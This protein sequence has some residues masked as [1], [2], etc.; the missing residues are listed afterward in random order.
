[1]R[2][3]LM[4]LI[5]PSFRR[6]PELSSRVLYLLQQTSF[7]RC[8][9]LQIGAVLK[10]EKKRNEE[11]CKMRLN[12]DMTNIRKVKFI[13]YIFHTTPDGF[14]AC[15]HPK[16]YITKSIIIAYVTFA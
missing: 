6:D 12:L 9:R 2:L 5:A 11:K 16:R 8:V 3:P 10:R 13:Y 1:M 7:H 4:R 14:R 15:D